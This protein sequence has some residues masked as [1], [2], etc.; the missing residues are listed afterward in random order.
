M[1]I[2]TSFSIKDLENLSGVKAH[3]IRI[4]E[5]RYALLEPERTETNIRTYDINNLRKILNI[6]ILLEHGYRISRIAM[7]DEKELFM[8]VREYSLDQ[9][10]SAWSLNAFKLSMLKFDQQLFENTYNQLST[11]YSFREIFT[12]AFLRLLDEIGTLWMCKTI[13][14][15]HEHFISTLIL[16]KL[17]INIERVQHLNP[18]G[19]KVFVL[20]LPLNEIHEIGLLYIHFELLIKGYRSVYLGQSVPVDNLKELKAIFPEIVYVSYFTIEPHTDQVYEYLEEVNNVILEER[21][22]HLHILG[23]NTHD[24]DTNK[25]PGSVTVH[26]NIN[27]LLDTI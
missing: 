21:K 14:P 15:A 25:L 5:K 13:T 1:S 24:L 20:F 8:K 17:Y 26:G 10:D 12:N 7:L 19:G 6:T 9:E 3:T 11:Q 4:W 22:E 18:E 16:Q 23:R 2:K 27:E